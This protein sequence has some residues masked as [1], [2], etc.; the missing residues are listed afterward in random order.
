MPGKRAPGKAFIG[1]WAPVE[2]RK[3]LK[4]LAKLRRITDT[5][6]LNEALSA[7]VHHNKNGEEP[8]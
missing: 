2:L 1:W 7:W 5:D 8:K 3:Q 4:V 6:A